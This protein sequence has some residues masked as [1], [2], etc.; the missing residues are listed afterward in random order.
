MEVTL[1]GLE[2][3]DKFYKNILRKVLREAEH[4]K[5]LNMKYFNP[6]TENGKTAVFRKRN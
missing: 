6:Y 1:A 2:N 5:N 3:S 4:W